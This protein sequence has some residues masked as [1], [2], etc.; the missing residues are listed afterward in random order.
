M[1][2]PWLWRRRGAQD[3]RDSMTRIL[4]AKAGLRYATMVAVRVKGD[5]S[6][7][8]SGVLI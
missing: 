4:L 5:D 3:R 8:M 7:P 1:P 2:N 6:I